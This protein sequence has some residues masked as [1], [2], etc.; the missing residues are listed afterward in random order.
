MDKQLTD[1]AKAFRAAIANKEDFPGLM[2]IAREQGYRTMLE[3][4]KSKAMAGWTT[5]DE[6]IKAVYTQAL[7]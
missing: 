4:G 1:R 2:R 6:V 7:D 5:P 3:D